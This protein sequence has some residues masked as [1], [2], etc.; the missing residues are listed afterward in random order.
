MWCVK[1]QYFCHISGLEVLLN[2]TLQIDI[3]LLTYLLT[4]Y[5]MP[6]T[7][8]VGGEHYLFFSDSSV[9]ALSVR[10]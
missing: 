6:P 4:F 2:R 10:A 5:I 8:V 9:H 3:Y 7:A 1:A